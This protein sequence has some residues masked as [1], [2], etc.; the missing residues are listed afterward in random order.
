M[1]KEE[2]LFCKSWDR[3]QNKRNFKYAHWSCF[4]LYWLQIW[5]EHWHLELQDKTTK[6]SYL[7]YPLL[8]SIYWLQ[9]HWHAVPFSVGW[10]QAVPMVRLLQFWST[11]F[12][13]RACAQVKEN[14][15]IPCHFVKTVA[16]RVYVAVNNPLWL[17]LKVKCFVPGWVLFQVM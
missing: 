6:L 4:V 7:M 14:D 17:L 5:G 10:D 1:L 8:Q 3:V 16:Y 12:Y 2:I 13:W 11:S 15:K 9:L